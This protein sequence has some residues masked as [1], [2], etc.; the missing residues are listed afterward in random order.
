[1]TMDSKQL[2][3]LCAKTSA[4]WLA[5]PEDSAG[6]P[7]AMAEFAAV[8]EEECVA[9]VWA[10]VHAKVRKLANEIEDSEPGV[11]M[12]GAVL[13]AFGLPDDD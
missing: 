2:Q 5:D 10:E 9:R 3:A 13:R 7:Q 4:P 8:V 6:V 11:G 12:G 1:M